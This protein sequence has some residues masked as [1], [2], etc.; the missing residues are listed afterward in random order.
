MKDQEGKTNGDNRESGRKVDVRRD[1]R[2]EKGRKRAGS[3]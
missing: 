3:S 1:P 2:E